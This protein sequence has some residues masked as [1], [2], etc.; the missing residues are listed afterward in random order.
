MYA[1]HRTEPPSV[2]ASDGPRMMIDEH[3][4]SRF[5]IREG[6]RPWYVSTHDGSDANDGSSPLKAMRSTELAHSRMEPG[7]WLLIQAGSQLDAAIG[8]DHPARHWQ[9][10]GALIGSYGEGP[11][12]IVHDHTGAGGCFV[13]GLGSGSPKDLDDI[14]ITGLDL[15]PAPGG[16]GIAWL[17]AGRRP[18]VDDTQA[19]GGFLGAN[20]LADPAGA[21][22]P[23]NIEVHRTAIFDQSAQG[24]RD[25]HTQGLF[26]GSPGANLRLRDVL[27]DNVAA[28]GRNPY[29]HNVYVQ[30]G[31]GPVNA[32]GCWFS[33]SSSHGIQARSGGWITDSFFVRCAMAGLLGGGDSPDPGGITGGFHRNAVL[34]GRDIDQFTP[35]AMGFEASNVGPLGIRIAHNIFAHKQPGA[36]A[37]GYAI[38]LTGKGTAYG[39]GVGVMAASVYGNAIHAWGTGGIWS[40]G[41]FESHIDAEGQCGT[42]RYPGRCIQTWWAAFQGKRTATTDSY[43]AA[44]RDHWNRDAWAEPEH[45]IRGLMK[46]LRAGHGIPATV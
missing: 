9:I 36:N 5:A 29:R 13:R 27:V 15:R 4:C 43:I 33:R 24:A 31:S 18:I 39:A 16:A 28:D 41:A 17:G 22:G 20:F 10:P 46:Y 25:G 38:T 23:T 2:A 6:S 11:R 30:T 45:P 34:E 40:N 26:V 32:T 12:P 44:L 14:T 42:K 19:I 3:G 1:D 7:D 35:R 21:G 37:D 8:S